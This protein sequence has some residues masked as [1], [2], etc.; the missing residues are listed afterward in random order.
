[1]CRTAH[2]HR[3][4]DGRVSLVYY[5]PGEEIAAHRHDFGQMSFVLAGD[6]V[7]ESIA[8]RTHV[9]GPAFGTKPAGYEHANVFGPAGT[10]ILSV[11]LPAE[12]GIGT[13]DVVHAP[14]T[15]QARAAPVDATTAALLADLG[16]D[17][18]ATGSR[19]VRGRPKPVWL[20][21][22]QGALTAARRPV[23]SLARQLGLHPVAFARAFRRAT[24]MSP[25]AFRTS[26]RLAW[27]VRATVLDTTPLADLALEAG[28][29]DQAHFSRAVR[30]ATGVA[31]QRLRALLAS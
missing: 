15:G 22:A 16:A 8:G 27:A 4:A 14:D 1:M 31:P 26:R 24:G 3:S 28:F 21:E 2:L 20:A 19:I 7:E 18:L 6:Y 9:P 11:S 23:G 12:A 17:R 13:Y 25:V 30:A 5:E 10:L 29:A